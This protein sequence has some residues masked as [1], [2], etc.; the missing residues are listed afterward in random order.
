VTVK[1]DPADELFRRTH[2]LSNAFLDSFLAQ[3]PGLA[4]ATTPS[5][6]AMAT[7]DAFNEAESVSQRGDVLYSSF[8]AA[9][10]RSRIQDEL[11][12][13]GSSLTVDNVL[14]R[15]TTQTCAGCHRLSAFTDLGGSVGAWPNDNFFV[16]VDESG[17]LSDALVNE[18][19]P[20]RKRVLDDFIA[21]RCDGDSGPI[22]I[23]EGKTIG[24]QPVGAAN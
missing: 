1:N 8:A 6:V 11:T 21:A 23:D 5:E 4:A 14:D 15:A 3:V 19:L 17:S 13:I 7:D 12:A 10:V 16:H 9:K 22:V 20:F 2:P 24:G 18:F